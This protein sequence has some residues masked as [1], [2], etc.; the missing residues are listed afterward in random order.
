MVLRVE[1]CQVMDTMKSGLCELVDPR[2]H[3]TCIAGAGAPR[4]GYE[5]DHFSQSGFVVIDVMRSGVRR[6]SQTRVSAPSQ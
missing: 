6:A 3:A 4:E 1:G 5:L 2:P